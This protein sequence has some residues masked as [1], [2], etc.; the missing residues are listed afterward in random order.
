VIEEAHARGLKVTGHLAS[1]GCGEAVDLGIDNIEHSFIS[2][3]KDLGMSEGPGGSVPAPDPERARLL[4]QRLVT[5]GVAL[6]STPLAVERPISK[7]ELELL[8][9]AAR[10]RYLTMMLFVPPS[11]ATL[12]RHVRQLEREFVAAGGRLIIGSD[13][14]DG[15][16]IAGY[17]DHRALEL[18]VEAGWKPIEV[19]RMATLAGAQFLGVGDEVGSVTAGKAADLIVVNGNP[20]ADINDIEKV[21]LVLKDG[22]VYDPK[23]LRDSV[24][25]L[26]GWH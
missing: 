25:G 18:L 13:P 3:M 7:E 5:A 2:C 12:E 8:H 24:R 10:E 21:E 16:K 20:V 15:G 14:Q 6:T 26:V 17:A 11:R 9:P 19:I 22:I 4:I 23:L 1:V